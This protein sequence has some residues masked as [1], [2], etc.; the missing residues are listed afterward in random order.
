MKLPIKKKETKKVINMANKGM[1]L[2]E[3]VDETNAYYLANDIACIHKKPIPIQVVHVQYPARNKALIDEAYY[4]TPSTTDYNG[5]YKGKYIDF[6]CKECNSTTSFPLKNV[7]EHQIR[8]L[9]QVKMHGGIAFLL[10][11]WWKYNEYYVLP[12]D[13][14][15]KCYNESLNGGLKSIPYKDFKNIAIE[16]YESFRPRLNYLKA[17]DIL[18]EE[19]N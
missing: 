19:N 5:V 13:S 4:R 18:V 7:H 12:I 8:H 2:E 17:V 14:F 3:M 11:M 10:V 1:D 15:M 6:D 16:V 9:N